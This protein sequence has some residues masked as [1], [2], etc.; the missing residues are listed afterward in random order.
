MKDVG[1]VITESIYSTPLIH[2]VGSHAENDALEIPGFGGVAENFSPGRFLL[3]VFGGDVVQDLRKLAF[4]LIVIIRLVQQAADNV[5][6]LV[7]LSVLGQ[8]SGCLGDP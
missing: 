7:L 1:E 3:G 4:N 2:H 6:G 8:P 5:T